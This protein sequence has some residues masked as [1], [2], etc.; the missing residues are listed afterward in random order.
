MAQSQKR[1]KV[2]RLVRDRLR[3]SR[4]RVTDGLWPLVHIGNEITD[5]WH[6]FGAK[7][8]AV[9]DAIV[10]NAILC[11]MCLPQRG[12]TTTQVPAG[13][14]HAHNHWRER[15]RPGRVWRR[16]T[17]SPR[18]RVGRCSWRSSVVLA[19]FVSGLIGVFFGSAIRAAKL[20]PT[21]A[22]RHS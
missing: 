4:I 21:D 19:V 10:A 16:P 13:G 14:G 1:F 6:D 18:G 15:W 22:L 9:E 2:R 12:N 5:A 20:D 7:S 3:G 11:V 8:R 17:A